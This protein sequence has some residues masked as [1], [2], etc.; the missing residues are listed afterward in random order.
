MQPYYAVC[1]CETPEKGGG[2][3]NF[4]LSESGRLTKMHH[5]P[6]DRPMYAVYD[7]GTISVALRQVFGNESGILSLTVSENGALTKKAEPVTTHGVVACH[8]LASGE[9][10]YTV[11]YLSGSIVKLP[12][13]VVSHEGHGINPRQDAPHPHG[14]IL[15]PDGKYVLAADLG[16]DKIFVFR[17]DLAPVFE[18]SVPAGNGAR[19]MVFS[20]CGGYLYCVCELSATISVLRYNDGHLTYLHDTE[21]CARG[22]AAAIRLSKDGRFL[23]VSTR[24]EDTVTV[25]ETEDKEHFTLRGKFSCGGEYPR[26]IL[27][28]PDEKFLLCAGERSHS[29][30]VFA[31]QEGLPVE[32]TDTYSLPSPICITQFEAYSK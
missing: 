7:N 29:L 28:S 26:D 14:V 22:I 10:I 2:L 17:R 31:L 16:L 15:S 32:M 1:S 24:G 9:D 30:T 18:A 6:L 13:T 4:S 19:H 20:P 5:L 8:L 27:L 23:Y 12:H 3:Y 21:P 25:L 11:N